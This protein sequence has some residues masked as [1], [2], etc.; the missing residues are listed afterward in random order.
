MGK[1][2]VTQEAGIRGFPTQGREEFI[3]MPDV[4]FSQYIGFAMPFGVPGRLWFESQGLKALVNMVRG[5]YVLNA[6][7][8]FNNRPSYGRHGSSFSRGSFTFNGQYTG[9]SFADYLLGLVASTSRNFPLQTFGVS[10]SPY[11]ALNFQD[12]WK[13]TPMKPRR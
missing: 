1:E 12:F 2:N 8:E 13:V 9:N 6:G 4:F 10:D 5:D 3:G 7:Y 11:S